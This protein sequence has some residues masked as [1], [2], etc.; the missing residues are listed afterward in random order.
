MDRI[1]SFTVDHLRL[2]PGV[3]VS[4]QDTDP[5]TQAVVTTFDIR[6]IAPNREPV[7]DTAAIHCLE[8]LGATFLRNEEEWK[9]RVVYFGPMGCRTGFY[10]VVFGSY[11]SRDVI[12][13]VKRLFE[14]ARDFEGDVPGATPIECGNFHD[15]DLPM[16]K[17]WAKRFVDRTLESIDEAHMTYPTIKE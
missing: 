7:L 6:L 16:A 4:R 10:L 14:F 17:W 13:L 5:D 2:E 1:A 11:E 3:Y 9:H 15:C 12:D 8:H